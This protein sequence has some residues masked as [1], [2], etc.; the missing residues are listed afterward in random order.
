MW[1][2]IWRSCFVNRYGIFPILL[3][4]A[5]LGCSR[6]EGGQSEART[7]TTPK[8]APQITPTAFSE[9]LTLSDEQL[10]DVDVARLNLL[11]AQGLPGAEH[12]DIEASLATLDKWG[13]IA[14]AAERK[15]LPQFRANP[16]RYDNSLALFKAVNLALTLKEDLKC[17]YNLELVNS[18]VMNDVRSTRFFRNSRDLFLHGFTTDP[19]AGSCAS[20]PVLM[21]ALGRRLGYP[22]HLVTCKGHQFVRWDDGKDRFNIET[23]IQGADSKPDAYYY[24]WPHPTTKAEAGNEGYLVNL[25]PKQELANFVQIRGACLQENGDFEGASKAYELALKVFPESRLLSQYLNYVRTR[26]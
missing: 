1:K 17:G 4:V 24:T 5:L 25:T 20:L 11:C 7:K 6:K 22:L 21:V 13:K 12:L 16:G 10:K 2:A 18:G 8:E 14:K 23:A 9:L 3:L 26:I 15:Y 19:R